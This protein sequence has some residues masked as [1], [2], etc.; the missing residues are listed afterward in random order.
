MRP[1]YQG[2]SPEEGRLAT[3]PGRMSNIR[4]NGALFKGLISLHFPADNSLRF[5]RGDTVGRI[6]FRRRARRFL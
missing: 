2:L 6:L 5:L 1:G 4:E 3:L